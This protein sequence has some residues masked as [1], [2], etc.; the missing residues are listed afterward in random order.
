MR[1]KSVLTALA[2]VA[3]LFLGACTGT[4][5]DDGNKVV[6][7]DSDIQLPG[8]TYTFAQTIETYRQFYDPASI[9][10]VNDTLLLVHDTRGGDNVCFL[11]TTDGRRVGEFCR[12]GRG[13]SE[14]LEPQCPWVDKEG[15]NI[16]IYDYKTTYTYRY[17]VTDIL[18][19]NTTP[20][21]LRHSDESKYVATRFNN[22]QH[23]SK[24]KAVC[25]G[26]D[27]DCRFLI[28]EDEQVKHVYADY[29]I[30]DND[31][32]VN[33]SIW[34][35]SGLQATSMDGKHIVATT[36]IGAAFET[37]DVEADGTIKSRATK[38]YYNPVYS[39]AEG[40][41]PAYATADINAYHGF[42]G[43]LQP[44]DS[45]FI[46]VL[47]GQ[48]PDSITCNTVV[49]YDYDGNLLNKYVV[50]DGYVWAMAIDSHRNAYAF[51]MDEE[52]NIT[53]KKG[54]FN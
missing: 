34:T 51:V 19:G 54:H 17:G 6:F 8:K 31:T 10:I 27:E 4:S 48:G 37:F 15:A 50:Q 14:L 13:N 44:L 24:N 7:N 21:P 38:A 35:S 16:Y 26:S 3:S 29:P 52:G 9:C 23:L 53:L 33:R 45:S 47:N 43:C 2:C 39:I 32:E 28:S 22:V 49:E 46:S 11:L 1:Q 41:H 25:Y 30:L 5:S 40:S 18:G 12:I 42:V 20:E 36:Y